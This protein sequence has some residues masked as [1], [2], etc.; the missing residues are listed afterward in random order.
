M[1]KLLTILFALSAYVSYAYDFSVD[2]LYYTI[3]SNTEGTCAVE[4]GNIKYGGSIEIP[5]VVTYNNRQFSVTKISYRAFDSCESLTSV[6]IPNSVTYISA[7]AFNNC[8]ALKSVTIPNS[9]ASIGESAFCSCISLASVDIPNSITSIYYQTFA[10]CKSLTSVTIPNSVTSIEG[11]AFY[12][13]SSLTS[14]TISNSVTSIGNGV[15]DRCTSLESFTIPNSVTNIGTAVFHGCIS[16]K[17]VT[18]PNSVT[19]IGKDSFGYCKSLISVTIPN[20][21]TSIGEFAFEACSSLTSV[22]IPNSVKSIGGLAFSGCKNLQA[23]I[24]SENLDTINPGIFSECNKIERIEIPSSVRVLFQGMYSQ[25]HGYSYE[26]F[27]KCNSLET[28]KILYS[29]EIIKIGYFDDYNGDLVVRHWREISSIRNLYL[30]RK[31]NSSMV[32]P[33]LEELVL[34][35]H[36]DEVQ[37]DDMQ[38]LRQLKSIDCRALEPPVLQELT[39]TQYNNILVT[40][41]EES[42]EAY[43]AHPVWG[44]FKCLQE[45]SEIEEVKAVQEKAMTGRFDISGSPVDENFKGLVIVRFSD[46]TAKKVFQK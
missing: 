33:N 21:V 44:Q 31:M 20:S 26:T 46:G 13:C 40:V 35:E 34:G 27:Y 22:I 8:T 43:R 25:D 24:L 32:V 45:Y 6:M 19:S 14:V 41:P 12:G 11:Y 18:I 15:F 5:A 7:Q 17:S 30:D 23:I 29:P 39:A 37:V 3:T 28:F 1:K 42:I 4:K 36:V 16:L 38:N 2:G 9:V 10:G